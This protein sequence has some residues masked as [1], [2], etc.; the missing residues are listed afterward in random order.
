M[1][2]EGAMCKRHGINVVLK[3]HRYGTMYILSMNGF[4]AEWLLCAG[5]YGDIG[6]PDGFKNATRICRCIFQGPVAMHRT[7]AKQPQRRMMGSKQDRKGILSLSDITFLRR[8]LAGGTHIMPYDVSVSKRVHTPRQ[9][10][11][12]KRE[13]TWIAVKPERDTNVV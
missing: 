7:Y 11:E 9:I 2:L 4:A 3:Y 12:K 10:K 13:L 1:F 6:T 8:R 5:V